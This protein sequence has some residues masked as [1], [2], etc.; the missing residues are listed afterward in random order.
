MFSVDLG[1]QETGFI[2]CDFNLP[3]ALKLPFDKNRLIDSVSYCSL[4]IVLK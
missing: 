4:N 3:F 1:V 2:F